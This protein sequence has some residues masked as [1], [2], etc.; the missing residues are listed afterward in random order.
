MNKDEKILEYLNLHMNRL[1]TGI[2]V[3]SGGLVGL[4]ITFSFTFSFTSIIKSILLILGIFLL[5][6]MLIGLSNTGLEIKERLK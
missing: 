4:S 5:I 2:I 6:S 3:L 1:W